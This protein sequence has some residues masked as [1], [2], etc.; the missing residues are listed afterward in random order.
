MKDEYPDS[1]VFARCKF[2]GHV[3]Y[4]AVNI[5]RVIDAKAKREIANYAIAGHTVGTMTLAQF[6]AEKEFGC[7]CNR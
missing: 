2:C 1:N 7:K 4:I 3:F 6:R 5:P